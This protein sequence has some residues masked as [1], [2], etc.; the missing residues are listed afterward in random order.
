[1]NT[2]IRVFDR[3]LIR[4]RRNRAAHQFNRFDFLK[5]E[6]A[7][8]LIDRLDDI[9]RSFPV[10]LDLGAHT[11]AM[12]ERLATR[13]GTQTVFSTDITEAMIRQAKSLRIVGD[14]EAL[15]VAENS[16]DLITSCLSLHWVNDLPGAMIQANRALKPDGLFLAALLGGATLQE[17]RQALMEA[18]MA[19]DGG[20]S[21]R[22]SPF[23]DVRDAGSLLQRAGFALPV[24]DS[25][26]ITVDY[27]NA[28]LLMRD[29]RGMGETN[30]VIE[31]RRVP[32]RRRLL[33]T[34]VE[35]Y[36]DLF[37]RPDGRIPA[38]FE[39]IY[40]TGWAPHESQQQPLRPGS[41]KVRLA[42]ALGTV[43]RSAGEKAG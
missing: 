27:E 18:E 26:T 42:D 35:A 40:L 9:N 7:D 12:C 33:Q 14:E 5:T 25:D 43:E 28:L 10:A 2:D 24:A 15:P 6:V 37:A 21:P 34:A 29:L 23:A 4:A 30:A 8:R 20:I 17:L 36:H 39:I 19:V 1:M 3:S 16:L 32:M 22:I 13:D 41:A 11:G 38:T 31:R